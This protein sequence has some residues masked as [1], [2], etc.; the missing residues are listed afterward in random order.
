MKPS[1]SIKKR[2][3]QLSNQKGNHGSDISTL[4]SHLTALSEATLEH[5]D[6][7]EE[8]QR[9]FLQTAK[10]LTKDPYDYK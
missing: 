3:E 1:D 4:F 7:Q 8:K 9:E 5:L 6:K 2:A 10:D